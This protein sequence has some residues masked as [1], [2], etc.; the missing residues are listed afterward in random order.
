LLLFTLAHRRGGGTIS[1]TVDGTLLN[2]NLGDHLHLVISHWQVLG[3]LES[4]VLQVAVLLSVCLL[5]IANLHFV[6]LS[7]LDNAY[8]LGLP[9]Q[10]VHL[11]PFGQV[12]QANILDQLLFT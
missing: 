8:L 4:I 5:R 2:L 10:L 11:Y 6:E 3:W 12:T 9:E 7:W 1:L